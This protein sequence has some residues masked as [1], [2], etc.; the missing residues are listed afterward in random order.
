M[1][2]K[3]SEELELIKILRKRIMVIA[4]ILAVSLGGLLAFGPKIGS[5]FGMISVNR[6]QTVSPRQAN[7]P[8]PIFVDV[9]LATNKTKINLKGFATPKS[10]VVLFVNGPKVG[11]VIADSSGEFLFTNVELNKAKNTIFA[12]V[13]NTKSAVI[14]IEYDGEAPKIELEGL[15]DKDKVENLNDRIEIK[16]K[17]N[18]K[19][20]ITINDKIVIQRPDNTFSFLLGA[21]EGEV[22]IKIKAKDLAGNISEKNLKVQYKKE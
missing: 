21:K 13:G 10:S 15:K 3:T 8:P 22:E 4:L 19:A 2:Q 14:T 11:S 18:E 6:N 17:L 1:S 5:L 7:S 20:E 12:R 9:P 16:G